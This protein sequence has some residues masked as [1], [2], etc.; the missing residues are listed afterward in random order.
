MGLNFAICTCQL[1]STSILSSIMPSQPINWTKVPHTELVSDLEDEVEVVEAKAGEKQR[2]EEE[3]KAE[4]QRQK[5]VHSE[6]SC[7]WWGC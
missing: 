6:L 2:R 3:A 4:R 7:L 1:P 5:E